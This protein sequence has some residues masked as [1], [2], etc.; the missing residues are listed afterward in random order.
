MPGFLMRKGLGRMKKS[1][2]AVKVSTAVMS[3]TLLISVGLSSACKK[4]SSESESASVSSSFGLE[5]GREEIENNKREIVR[6]NA[7][8]LDNETRI[9]TLN[10]SLPGLLE[11]SKLDTA[12]NSDIGL[13]QKGLGD[14]LSQAASYE[15]WVTT[16]MERAGQNAYA[17]SQCPV[18]SESE[19]KK[20]ELFDNQERARLVLNAA[21]KSS[22][23]NVVAY[24]QAVETIKQLG[25]INLELKKRN[26][27]LETRNQ[28]LTNRD[29]KLKEQKVFKS[30][31]GD[32]RIENETA[33]GFTKIYINGK[34]AG[35]Q[36]YHSKTG[37]PIKITK[38][39]DAEVK[40]QAE[41]AKAAKERQER[42]K[43]YESEREH[44]NNEILK[45]RMSGAAFKA[46]SRMCNVGV[47][48]ADST[49]KATDVVPCIDCPDDGEWQ[50]TPQ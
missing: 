1:F 26:Q 16:C 41:V 2:S 49:I 22:Q 32:Y 33:A 42:L 47:D 34:R 20:R 24:D 30:D 5:R 6:N 44:D 10:A 36:Q 25:I 7:R 50:C 37:A 15:D 11:K 19:A 21:K 12:P 39:S 8:I 48:V 28:E 45:Q 31:E 3:F 14:A 13:A 9:G 46:D 18:A 4:Q 17:K 29:P 43:R 27:D 35:E 23:P 38:E 40:R